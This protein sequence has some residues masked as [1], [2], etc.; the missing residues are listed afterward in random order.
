MSHQKFLSN[1]YANSDENFYDEFY[2]Q[3]KNKK[4]TD[5]II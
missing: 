1:F 3:L 5:E 2:L 4:Y